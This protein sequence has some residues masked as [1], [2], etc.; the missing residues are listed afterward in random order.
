M[1]EPSSGSDAFALKTRAEKKGDHFVINGS[2]SWITNAGHA[3]FFVVFAN[4]DPSAGHRGI[5][6]FVV[7][8]DTPGVHVAKNENKLGIRASS[9]CVVSFDNVQVP[10]S[11]VIGKVGEGYKYAIATLNEGRIGIGAQMLGLA[12]G[13]FEYAVKYTF[14]R[15]QFGQPIFEFQVCTKKEF[16]CYNCYNC[17]FA[18]QGMQH[19]IAK[20]ATDIESARLLVY[21][22]AR[23]SEAGL[24]YIKEAAMAK[25]FAS[26]VACNASAK[27]VEWL[28]GVGFTKDFPVE[29]FYRDSKIGS[30]YEGTSNIQLNTIA[31]LVKGELA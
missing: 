18:L 20:I 28:G 16:N 6:C 1:S 12:E 21:N 29:K 3:G 30:I 19:Q 4:V 5:T 24:P 14:E 27:A 15:K 8:R 31:K 22:A 13:V 2:K 17:C 9:T 26:E 11:N 7:D 23:L 10:A 25:Y